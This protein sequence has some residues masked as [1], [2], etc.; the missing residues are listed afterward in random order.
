MQL[1]VSLLEAYEHQTLTKHLNISKV[2]I[3]YMYVQRSTTLCMY[4]TVY[5]QKVQHSVICIFKTISFVIF[6][7]MR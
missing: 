1:D 5:L 4:D 7:E 2:V 3:R 6:L